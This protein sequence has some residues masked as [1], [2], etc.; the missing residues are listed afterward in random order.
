[1]I[2][3]LNALKIKCDWKRTCDWKVKCG[4]YCGW[5]IGFE[6]VFDGGLSVLALQVTVL[7]MDGARCKEGL[8]S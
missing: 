3:K 8:Y 7:E 1:M 2:A 6:N 4:G 5:C